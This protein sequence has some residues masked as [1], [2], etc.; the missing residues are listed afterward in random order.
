MTNLD[1][2]LKS[3]DIFNTFANK[4]PYI[5]S[6]GFSSSHV[7]L[8]EL[9]YKESWVP[10]NWCFWTVCW[11]RLL[12]IPWT[13]RRSNQSV[14]KKI[15]PECSLEGLMLKLKLQYFGHL[16]KDPDAGKDWRWEEKGMTEDEMVGWHYRLNGDEFEQAPGVG[17]GS[18]VCCSPWGCKELDMT[19]RLNWA[20][21]L[22]SVTGGLSQT[23]L[24]DDKTENL[25]CSKFVGWRQH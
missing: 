1:R 5:Q 21:P 10:K 23:I 11:R 19:E 16:M 17:Q 6:Y 7:C 8:W 24:T 20:E 15:S 18:L 3:R 13:P 9:D 22:W 25:L 12:R 2:E 4:G 14:L